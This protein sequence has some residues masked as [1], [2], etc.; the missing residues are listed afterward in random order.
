MLYEK[1]SL[2]SRTETFQSAVVHIFMFFLLVVL[3]DL[4]S[5]HSDLSHCTRPPWAASLL[6]QVP[7]DPVPDRR[8]NRGAG[9][10]SLSETKHVESGAARVA[11][12]PVFMVALTRNP[13]LVSWRSKYGTNLPAPFR[14][15]IRGN[16]SNKIRKKYYCIYE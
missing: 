16:R 10:P 1:K 15:R 13:H 7:G 9:L 8:D 3:L 11:M 14:F 12:V 2:V 6:L 5:V 4:R